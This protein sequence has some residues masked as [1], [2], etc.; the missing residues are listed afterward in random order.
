MKRN[1]SWAAISSMAAIVALIISLIFNVISVRQ[2]THATQLQIITEAHQMV[3]N[4]AH[5]FD[6]KYGDELKLYLDD[7]KMLL[8]EEAISDLTQTLN[9]FEYMA[10]LFNKGYVK[11]V[12]GEELWLKGLI[13]GI[14]YYFQ[15]FKK[16]KGD[17]ALAYI[18]TWYPECQQLL[19][20]T[21]R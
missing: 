9:D 4:S 5:S 17:E 6:A 11:D 16:A 2:T 14:D 10:W 3:N 21:Q 19:K 1:I 20:T 7:G 8:S 18:E 12:G 13:V 15:A